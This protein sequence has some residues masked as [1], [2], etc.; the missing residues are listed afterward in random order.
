M[1]ERIPPTSRSSTQ[2]RSGAN[3][4]SDDLL[5][6]LL[7]LVPL[8][9]AVLVLLLPKRAET[10]DQ[11][12]LPRGHAGHLRADAGGLRDLHGPGLDTPR[13]LLS[14]R[15]E[16]N[17]SS[18]RPR[19]TSDATGARRTDAGV[20]DLV[21]RRSWIPY[22]NIEYY[23]GLDGIS[24]SLVLLTGL[25][26]VLA[27]L[28]SWTIEKQVKGYFSL[29]LLL[30]GEHD[31]RLPLARPVPVLRLLRGDAAAD[32]LPDRRLGRRRTASTRR[33]SSCSTR[34]SARSSSWSPC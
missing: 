27:C 9:G 24:L 31:G 6:T 33:S 23:L 11:G 34:S 30:T 2:P 4:M 16:N 10:G 25:V 18:T 32:V 28:A 19:A 12:V 17:T 3:V 5:L 22:F 26:S 7:W 29:F 15:A 1:L 14:E 20:D 21:V 8:L 13:R